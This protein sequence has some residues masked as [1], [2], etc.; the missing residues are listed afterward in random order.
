[1]GSGWNEEEKLT[2]LSE[3]RNLISVFCKG[4]LCV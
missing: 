3:F 2:W 4:K 1:M